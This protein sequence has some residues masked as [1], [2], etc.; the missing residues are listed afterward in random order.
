[1]TDEPNAELEPGHGLPNRPATVAELD[2]LERLL[3]LADA[4]PPGPWTHRRSTDGTGVL[5]LWDGDEPL[6][7]IYAGVD[8]CKYLEAVAPAVLFAG[9]AFGYRS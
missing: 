3:E 7:L 9:R 4:I 8:F 6:A 5:I 2:Q 1:M